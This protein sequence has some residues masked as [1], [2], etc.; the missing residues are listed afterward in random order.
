MGERQQA[1]AGDQ[2]GEQAAARVGQVEGEQQHRQRGDRD[3]AQPEGQRAPAHPQQ[4]RDPGPEGEAVGVP[5]AERIAQSRAA[6]GLGPE[7]EDVRQQAAAKSGQGDQRQSDRDAFSETLAPL[8]GLGDKECGKEEAEVDQDPIRLGDAQLNRSRPERRDCRKK[9]QPQDQPTRPIE[10]S[11]QASLVPAAPKA[12]SATTISHT[13]RPAMWRGL[14]SKPPPASAR[15]PIRSSGAIN[16]AD[17]SN[18][19]RHAWDAPPPAP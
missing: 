16:A 13:A 2:Q 11:R 5:V 14:R 4:Q 8:V 12:S 15:P 10:R 19:A 17:S 9:R 7:V 3:P 18:L 1:A 6:A